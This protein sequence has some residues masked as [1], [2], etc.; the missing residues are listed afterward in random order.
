MS[1]YSLEFVLVTLV[2][3]LLGASS[4]AYALNCHL[5]TDCPQGF[6]CLGGDLNSP[7]SC[8]SG[9]CTADSDCGASFRC[10]QLIQSCAGD[11]GVGESCKPKSMC[12][13]Q[14]QAP[15]AQDVDCGPGFACSDTSNLVECPAGDEPLPSYA[16]ASTIPCSEVPKPPSPCGADAGCQGPG[17]TIPALCEPGTFCR[18]IKWKICHQQASETCTADSDCPST[19]T[20]VCPPFGDFVS[21]NAMIVDSDGGTSPSGSCRKTCLAP[22]S[23]IENG[24]FGNAESTMATGSSMNDAGAGH[25]IHA[26]RDAGMPLGKR[27]AGCSL[28][29][30]R[31]FRTQPVALFFAI[32]SLNVLRTRRFSRRS[33]ASARKPQR[34]A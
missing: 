33:R 9:S 27:S 10:W 21:S 2:G 11:S 4:T 26:A 18:S 15:C 17:I 13:P 12:V 32:V 31:P 8:I 24:G 29:A 19:W 1:K 6:Q 7:G 34:S 16:S 3:V 5:D 28:T 14:W 30:A 23:D 25:V 22:N 20:C